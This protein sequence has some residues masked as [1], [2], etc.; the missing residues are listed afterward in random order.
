MTT[1][2]ESANEKAD[3]IYCE[4]CNVPHRPS[5]TQCE[6]CG[7]AMGQPPDWNKVR[8]DIHKHGRMAFVALFFFIAMVA[9]AIY[10]ASV[11]GVG[12]VFIAPL[13]WFGFNL[14]KYK[15]LKARLPKG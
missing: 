4:V 3:V 13:I 2:P 7:H 8:Q 9:F 6:G 15:T 10:S 12:L 11:K 1:K 5:V 14:Y